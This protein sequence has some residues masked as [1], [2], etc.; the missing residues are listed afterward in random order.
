L[1]DSSGV[2][3]IDVEMLSISSD[4]ERAASHETGGPGLQF[5]K[6]VLRAL[7]LVVQAGQATSETPQSQSAATPVTTASASTTRGLKRIL[8]RNDCGR[9][10]RDGDDSEDEGDGRPS[11]KRRKVHEKE[12]T[13]MTAFL[14]CPFWKLDQHKH[15]GCLL[16][17]IKNINYL[18][19]H[20]HRRH[21]PLYCERCLKTFR[22]ENLKQDHLRA[23]T[24]L[25]APD[26]KLDGITNEQKEQL[27]RRQNGSSS[28]EALW[29]R[30]WVI[31]FPDIPPPSSIYIRP[32]EVVDLGQLRDAVE[33][34][35][36]S[37]V[38]DELRASGYIV[39]PD[40]SD[41]QLAHVSRRSM[42]RLLDCFRIRGQD[43]ASAGSD[44]GVGVASSGS[45]ARFQ[46][47]MPADRGE[48]DRDGGGDGSSPSNIEQ[49]TRP[50]HNTADIMDG[51][52]WDMG[53]GGLGGTGVGNANLDSLDSLAGLLSADL[54]HVNLDGLGDSGGL[55]GVDLENVNMDCL[56][57]LDD[58][59]AL[60]DVD[61]DELFRRIAMPV[62]DILPLR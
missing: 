47:A 16:K 40:V 44:S 31:L 32:D 55:G 51:T 10:G 28:V 12:D 37:I 56:D 14:A 39:R 49:H 53:P 19:T 1:S 7:V 25:F 61:L 35:A 38:A 46:V 15:W 4:S 58:M 33:T 59:V 48:C 54:E 41:E 50:E 62:A 11:R 60:E 8:P 57:A 24:C 23:T 9:D 17:Q 26:R 22:S 3:S 30:V 43:T 52:S 34:L 45:A 6:R 20:L 5:F 36:P 2:T 42:T 21:V 18:K 27:L 29:Y 13:E